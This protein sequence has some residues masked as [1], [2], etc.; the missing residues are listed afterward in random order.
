[1]VLHLHHEFGATEW[2]AIALIILKGYN[3]VAY[4]PITINKVSIV[5][6]VSG[7]QAVSEEII[8]H[9]FLNFTAYEEQETV[10]CSMSKDILDLDEGGT[11]EDILEIL[12]NF[13]CNQVARNIKGLTELPT[14]VTHKEL[15]QTACYIGEA[16][17]TVFLYTKFIKDVNEMEQICNQLVPSCKK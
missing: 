17:E 11:H 16:F 13:N 3:Y 2:T 9:S 10:R 6:C 8:F 14:E 1:M 5:S 12:S 7:E 4:Y 15:I